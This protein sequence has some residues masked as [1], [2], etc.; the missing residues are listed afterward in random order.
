MNYRILN[1]DCVCNFPGFF[2]TKAKAVNSNSK[3]PPANYPSV[4]TQRDKRWKIQAR[5][6]WNRIDA[7]HVRN[8]IARRLP[9]STKVD[10]S[11]LPRPEKCYLRF[12]STPIPREGGTTTSMW[13]MQNGHVSGRHAFSSTRESRYTSVSLRVN[14]EI[15]SIGSLTP[16]IELF[17]GYPFLMKITWLTR[18]VNESIKVSRAARRR[19]ARAS[20]LYTSFFVVVAAISVINATRSDKGP[21][22]SRCRFSLSIPREI[23]IYRA[24]NACSSRICANLLGEA[25]TF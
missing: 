19:V 17:P 9:R 21:L 6:G 22:I 5:I 20:T 13:K 16:C 8:H 7:S 18:S 24:Q 2:S 25:I 1:Y 3:M 14:N 11:S 10:Q 15:R 12:G 4:Q 23:R